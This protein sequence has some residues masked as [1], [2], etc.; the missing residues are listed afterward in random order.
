MRYA[1]IKD[2]VVVSIY[3]KNHDGLVMV[4]DNVCCGMILNGD[5]FTSPDPA[6]LSI[7]DKIIL[8]ESK[9]TPRILREAS[10]GN[11]YALSVLSNIEDEIKSLRDKL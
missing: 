8:L 1:L 4:D 7:F 10:L 2:H 11:E 6:E 9:Q 5:K 3:S